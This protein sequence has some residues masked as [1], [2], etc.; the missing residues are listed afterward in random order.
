MTLFLIIIS[1]P[2]VQNAVT[3]PNNT[4]GF[5]WLKWSRQ[6]TGETSVRVKMIIE[7]HNLLSTVLTIALWLGN[8]DHDTVKNVQGK[9]MNSLNNLK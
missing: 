5:P 6:I 7:P 2:G 9:F 3:A 8:D 1:Q 4:D